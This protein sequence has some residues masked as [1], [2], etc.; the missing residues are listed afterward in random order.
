MDQVFE[1]QWTT[2]LGQ[3]SDK[4]D[5]TDR[6]RSP[7][8]FPYATLARIGYCPVFHKHVA[9]LVLDR[10]PNGETNCHYTKILFSLRISVAGET[11]NTFRAVDHPKRSLLP[12]TYGS[13]TKLCV[14]PEITCYKGLNIRLLTFMCQARADTNRRAR[15][16]FPADCLGYPKE[17]RVR[18]PLI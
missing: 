17:H 12:R 14:T 15:I 2:F 16:S 10:G 13:C 7:Q 6:W 1:V 18:F 5:K 9:I 3:V 11:R 8:W 4:S